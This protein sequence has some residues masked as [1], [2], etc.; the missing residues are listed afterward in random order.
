[1]MKLFISLFLLSN[2]ALPWKMPEDLL[3]GF[4]FLGDGATICGLSLA[5]RYSRDNK[6][7]R[8]GNDCLNA[9][10]TAGTSSLGLK[11]LTHC[12]RP[13]GESY[14]S[15]PSGHTTVAFST[16]GVLS[17]YYPK[18]KFIFYLLAIGVAVAR[19]QC[20][21]HYTRDVIGG[22]IVGI[23]G[24]KSALEEKGILPFLRKKF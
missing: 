12:K 9:F 21:A 20:R 8:A 10:L 18:N 19:V 4:N 6:K 2:F 22:A 13:N 23:W 5:L 7:I 16:A 3:R 14:D 11:Y 1:M 24:A 15:F 17:H